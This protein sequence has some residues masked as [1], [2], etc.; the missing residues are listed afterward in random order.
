MVKRRRSDTS[1][2]CR[3]RKL[4]LERLEERA[5]PAVVVSPGTVSV[6]EGQARQVSFKLNKAP[7]ADVTFTLSI[8]N[9]AEAAVDKQSLTFTPVNWKTPQVVTVSAIED[10]VKDG[11]KTLKLVTG[12]S[13]STDRN[14]ANKAVPDVTVKTIDSKKVQ[15]LDPALYQ[16]YY[17]GNFTGARA[18]GTISANIT[19]R[20]LNVSILVNAPSAGIFE[21]PASGAGTIAD[22]GS[23]SFTAQGTVFGATYTGKLVVGQ[24]GEVSATGTWKYGR[25]ASGTWSVSRIA[26]PSATAAVAR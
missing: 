14:Y 19:G 15:P 17:S 22:D 16:G 18:F 1:R 6:T 3:N 20:T 5:V 12:N 23:F 10:W 24:N 7:T 25:I 11:N 26:A 21:S 2:D 8:S 13:S 9:A 4:S